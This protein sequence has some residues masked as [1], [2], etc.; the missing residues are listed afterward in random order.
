LPN[1]AAPSANSIPNDAM[2]G[3][4]IVAVALSVSLLALG[5]K[6][7]RACQRSRLLK[8][9]IAMLEAM[10]RISSKK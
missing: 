6:R 4:V 8:R 7:Y 2:L 10:W 1:Q 3:S 9:Q 5:Y